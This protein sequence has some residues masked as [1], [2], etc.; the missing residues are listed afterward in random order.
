MW[1]TTASGFSEVQLQQ[2]QGQN[3]A[4]GFKTHWITIEAF[5]LNLINLTFHAILVGL[6]INAFYNRVKVKDRDPIRSVSAL[7]PHLKPRSVILLPRRLS[8]SFKSLH[9]LSFHEFRDGMFL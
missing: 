8:G 1:P 7:A 6:T 9:R 5:G 4:S 3:Y 2:S